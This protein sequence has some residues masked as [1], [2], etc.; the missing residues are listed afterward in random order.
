MAKRTRAR[1]AWSSAERKSG[2]KKRTADRSADR[3]DEVLNRDGER[4]GADVHDIGGDRGHPRDETWIGEEGPRASGSADADGRPTTGGRT[5]AR[6]DRGADGAAASAAPE[7]GTHVTGSPS[8]DGDH[9][10][11]P[12]T[13]D[14]PADGDGD[15]HAAPRA[16]A[17]NGSRVNGRGVRGDGAAAL[18][19][20][21]IKR[22]EQRLLQEREL[23]LRTLVG[24][25]TDI[26]RHPIADMRKEEMDIHLAER[27][28][29]FL[30]LIDAAL[31]RLRECPEDFHL[32]V[33]SGRPIP[34]ERLEMV[35]WTRRLTN[36]MGL[37]ATWL[38]S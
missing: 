6:Q 15:G 12:V 19:P 32:S 4:N 23:A 18:T 22:I 14:T 24:T 2:R 27:H 30:A 1:R 34:F 20:A 36:E 21:Q 10:A 5:H 37:P 13:A 28:S 17:T 29:E 7:G 33:V 9:G 38:E 16:A 25:R 35:P 8:A 3:A 31:R 11:A 26:Q